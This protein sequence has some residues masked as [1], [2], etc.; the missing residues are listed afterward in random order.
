MVPAL[1]PANRS[2]T[3]GNNINIMC[4]INYG[5]WFYYS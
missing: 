3:Y 4:I 5:N 2:E 1:I